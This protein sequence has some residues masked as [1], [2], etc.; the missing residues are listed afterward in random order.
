MIL[1]G[2]T[3][4]GANCTGLRPFASITSSILVGCFIYLFF[5]SLSTPLLAALTMCSQKTTQLNED[6]SKQSVK[7]QVS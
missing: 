5:Y 6:Q 2:N 3:N 7:I 1:S 4:S